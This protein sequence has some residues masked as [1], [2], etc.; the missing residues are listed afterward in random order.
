MM[1]PYTLF[2]LRTSIPVFALQ[3]QTNNLFMD[4]AHA[5]HH[6]LHGSDKP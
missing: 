2:L 6:C 3:A 5:A 4:I 1:R